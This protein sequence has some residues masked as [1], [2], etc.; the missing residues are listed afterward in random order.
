LYQPL[1]T[2]ITESFLPAILG[3]PILEEERDIFSLPARKGGLGI[4]NPV[5]QSDAA[6]S[7]S[8][9]STLIIREAI[10]KKTE[11]NSQDHRAQIQKTRQ[12]TRKDQEQ[13][14]DDTLA[15]IISTLS[16]TKQ[17]SLQAIA[18]E[19]VSGWLTVLPLSHNH[20]DL[21][22][23]EFRDALSMR[24]RRP[25]LNMPSHCDGCGE[26]FSLT[27]A[28][29]CKKGGL[30]TLRHNEIRD[31]FGDM[32]GLVWRNIRRE[33]MVREANDAEGI[34]ALVA[35]LG[36]RGAWHNQAE[37]LF[38][39]RVIDTDAQSY[40]SR[41]IPSLLAS[42]ETQKKLNITELVSYVTL[43]SLPWS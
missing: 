26:A 41:S 24:Y 43:P 20:F 8:R 4:R 12:K 11:F 18:K 14:D 35:D 30:V 3:S 33:P 34:P 7:H 6:Y 9:D 16:S 28:L 21:S 15:E 42:A 40:L 23:L 5:L 19:K 38:D 32:A 36:V 22:A 27:H 25:L 2:T 39:I 10:V 31:A 17:R 29:D 37:A 1:E 13:K